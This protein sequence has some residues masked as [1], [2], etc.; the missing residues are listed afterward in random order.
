MVYEEVKAIMK[1]SLSFLLAIYIGCLGMM[2]PAFAGETPMPSDVK[3]YI[4]WPRNG[5]VIPGGTFWL[6][7]GLRNA[8]LAPAGLAWRHTGHHHVLI[9]T[10][11]PSLD[12]P[13]PFDREHLHFGG[14]QS[15]ARITLPPGR[16]TLQL[17]LGD[18]NHLPHKPP[19]YSN[20][21]TVIV[22]ES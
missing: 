6:R 12:E 17:L 15:E 16:H 13:L 22:P 9:D 7:M 19:V 21:I 4:I 3:A 2:S 11:L 5:Q 10:E 18:H 20:K 14:G 1:P 8:G